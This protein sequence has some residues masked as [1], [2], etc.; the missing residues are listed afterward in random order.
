MISRLAESTK[1]SLTISRW[2]HNSLQTNQQLKLKTSEIVVQP[3]SPNKIAGYTIIKDI[4]SQPAL[5]LQVKID[6]IIHNHGQSL[7]GYLILSW[8]IIG[9]VFPGRSSMIHRCRMMFSLICQGSCD[10]AYN[11]FIHLYGLYGMRR[12]NSLVASC[13]ASWVRRNYGRPTKTLFTIPLRPPNSL[14]VTS[15]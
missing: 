15:V 6:R 9:F 1:L 4:Y 3:L 13:R 5:I 11:T 2:G 7:W 12:C 8:V 10:N 14:P